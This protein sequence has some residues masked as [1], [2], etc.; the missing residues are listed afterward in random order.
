MTTDAFE[1][2]VVAGMEYILEIACRG[3]P[4]ERQGFEWRRIVAEDMLICA[5]E[6]RTSFEDLSAAAR[7]A[8]VEKLGGIA[9]SCDLQAL[10]AG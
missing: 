7:H 5:Q 10:L 3:L 4:P 1:P 2:A 6:G 8:V 9:T